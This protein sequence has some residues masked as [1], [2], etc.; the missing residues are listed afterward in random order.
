[1]DKA[2]GFFKNTGVFR[3]IRGGGALKAIHAHE[4]NVLKSL[5]DKGKKLTSIF[6]KPGDGEGQI[7]RRALLRELDATLSEL[8]CARTCFEQAKDPEIIEACVYEIKSAESRYSFLLRRAKES[9]FSETHA[10]R[11]M[12]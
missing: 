6:A 9:G 10:E 5:D 8:R 11:I 7:E 12:R 2:L 3:F 1:M 4:A